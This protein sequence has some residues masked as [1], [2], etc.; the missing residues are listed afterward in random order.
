MEKLIYPDICISCKDF[1]QNEKNVDYNITEKKSFEDI[2]CDFLCSKC[3]KKYEE[4]GESIC[5]KC[6]MKIVGIKKDSGVCE[7]CLGKKKAMPRIRSVFV[8]NDSVMDIIHMFKYN[9]LVNLD[10]KIAYFILKSFLSLYSEEACPDYIFPVPMHSS[11]LRKRGYNQSWL[12]VYMA[13]KLALKNYLEFPEARKDILL[14]SI[15]TS[16]QTGFNAEERKKNVADTFIIKDTSLIA[17]KKILLVDDVVTTGSTIDE[18]SRILFEKGALS[19][20]AIT[21]ARAL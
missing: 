11:K 10:I 9:E 15:A 4:M 8:F 21:F 18:C 12:M 13:S 6:G 20:D 14:K 19:V 2:F 3:S 5:N 16:S 17:G 7:N 1:F